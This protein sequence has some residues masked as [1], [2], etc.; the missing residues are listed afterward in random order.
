MPGYGLK[1]DDIESFIRNGFVRIDEAFPQATAAEGRAILWRATGCDPIDRS[2]WTRAVVRLGGYS[3]PP[4]QAAASAPRLLAAFDQLV[5]PDRWL[6]REGL[7]TFPIRFPAGEDPGDTGWHVDVSYPPLAEELRND[8]FEWRINVFSRGRALLMLFLFSDVEECDAPTRIRVGSH[9]ETAR[10]LA[11]AGENGMSLK[12][13]GPRLNENARRPEVFA[14][15]KAGTVYLC[16]PF[17]VHAAQRH[18]GN[19]PRFL[20]Q[21]PLE[22]TQQFQI[23]GKDS[24][25]S[26]VE[27]AIRI[28]LG[29]E[30]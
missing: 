4:F 10:V 19:S 21:P 20:A 23:V 26:P 16:H 25:Y 28:A 24:G 27:R 3:D 17:L 11:P 5:G 22:M 14:T 29:L 8:L 30:L 1:P 12:E 7:G 15:G 13:L 2:T 6:C 9:L 18:R